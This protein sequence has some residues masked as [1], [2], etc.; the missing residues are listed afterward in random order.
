MTKVKELEQELMKH[1]NKWV[2]V[3]NNKVIAEANSLRAI[4]NKLSA[5]DR[6]KTPLITKV[7]AKDE[8]I[9]IA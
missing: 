7:T 5:E 2:A 4:Y 3:H 8:D 1:P 9:L 6:R